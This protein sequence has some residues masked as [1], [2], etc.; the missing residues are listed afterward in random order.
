MA[1][2]PIFIPLFDGVEF[3]EELS[4][5]I[6]WHS[7]F[8]PVQKKKNVRELHAAA[9]AS[10]YRQILEISTKSDQ[11]V[12]KRLSAFH[13]QIGE[14]PLESA[15]QGSK[16]FENGGPYRD[17]YNAPVREAKRDPRLQNSGKLIAF[18]F[19]DFR[20]PLT[21]RTAFYDWLY[22]SALFVHR[23]WLV[24]LDRYTGFS[25]IEFNP[26]KSI[27][28]Q[29]RSCALLLS[30]IKRDMLSER[31]LK[32]SEF[33]E[34]LLKH[35]YPP[36]A[37][38]LTKEP[39]PLF[40]RNGNAMEKYTEEQLNKMDVD[41]LRTIR[42]LT[43]RFGSSNQDVGIPISQLKAKYIREILELQNKQSDATP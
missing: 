28:C 6:T 20:F 9:M 32:P 29:A 38:H 5:Q 27:N 33:I 14:I 41:K 8:A 7:G 40:S 23:D 16:V 17:L 21:P 1:E 26:S 11:E 30:L 35:F 2:R 24:R 10:G 39:A 4:L 13:L 43:Q 36:T 15:F 19:R 34:L 3:V 42:D 31:L 25:D 18:E 22:I 12:G 37:K